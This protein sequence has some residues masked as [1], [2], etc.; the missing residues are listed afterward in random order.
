MTA[1]HEIHRRP[2]EGPD[3]V[4]ERDIE[5]WLEAPADGDQELYGCHRH[6]EEERDLG[7]QRKLARFEAVVVA[8]RQ[9]DERGRGDD[10]PHPGQRHAPLRP[11]HPHAAEAR[12]QVIAFADE[13]GG[14]GAEDDAVDVDRPQPAEGQPEGAAEIVGIV[15][16]ARQQD[17]DRRRDQEP[18]HAPIEPDPHHRPIDQL[19]QVDTGESATQHCPCLR[20]GAPSQQAASNGA[21]LPDPTP[22]SHRDGRG[23]RRLS[24][25]G[26][27]YRPG[28]STEPVFDQ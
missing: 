27:Q 25:T 11:W 8:E 20:Q 28:T 15:E 16:E 4:P 9:R 14:K 2:H 19:I 1:Q 13:E 22:S 21:N 10:V 7:E 12:H 5:R 23:A 3:Q 26:D 17:T 6:D 18:E 24:P